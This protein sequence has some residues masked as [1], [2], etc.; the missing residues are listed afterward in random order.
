[1]K[2]VRMGALA[3]L[4]FGILCW[5]AF[6]QATGE[7]E[8]AGSKDWKLAGTKS[9]FVKTPDGEKIHYLAA[10]NYVD[11][12]LLVMHPNDSVKPALGPKPAILFVPGW[13]MPAQI[14][15]KQ[16]EHF[17]KLTRV[18]AI[19]PRAQGQSS[20][21]PVGLFPAARARDIKAVI[22]A[23]HLQPVVLVGWSMGVMEVAAYVDQ[24][25]TYGIAGIVLVD[26]IAG[27]D[28]PP[29]IIPPFLR[30]TNAYQT[31][32]RKAT[33]AFVRSMY[34]TPQTEDYLKRVV[35]SA[36]ETPTNSM[37]TLFVG[38]LTNDYRPALAKMNVPVLIT[39][40]PGTPF[41]AGYTDMAQRI[42]GAK[43]ERFE[44]AGHAL[45]VDSPAKFNAA[46]E[47]FLRPLSGR[48]PPTQP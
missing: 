28:F 1:M 46:L 30:S 34:K 12:S 9:A 11:S 25:G 17:A 3:S 13:T 15:E 10:G 21:P 19:D 43:V 29:Q 33:D 37:I 45:F 2:F 41:D 26:G 4:T 24:F 42:P 36:M 22:D 23:L 44:G 5:F 18:V 47:D 38:L 27:A 48:W 6:G 7:A 16:I 40:A 14:W 35:D 8:A 20:K 39:F 32:R 31:D